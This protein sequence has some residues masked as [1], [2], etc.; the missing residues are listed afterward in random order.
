MKKNKELKD[1]EGV[2]A[3]RKFL[4]NST[5]IA[6]GLPLLSGLFPV[7]EST[8]SVFKAKGLPISTPEKGKSIIGGYGEWAASML[9][10]PA[11]LSFRNKRWSNV[12][13]WKT[14]ALAK[15]SE[16]LAKPVIKEVPKVTVEKKYSY[17]GLD[18]EELSWQLS[19]GNPTKAIV[20][21]PKNIKKP[22]PAILALHDHGGKKYF[23]KRKITKTSDEQH[24]LIIDHQSQDYGGRAWANEV[25]KRGYVVLVHDAFAFASRRVMYQD[26]EGIEWG[27]TFIGDKTDANPDKPEHVETYNDWS[28][29][30]ENTI[31]Q[32]LFCAGTTLPGVVL[33]EDQIAL[34]I[35]SARPDVDA[36]RI[37]C[38]GLSG[39]GLRTVFLGGMD[40][41]IKCAVCVG[42][43]ST[44][45]D[46]VRYKSY[47]HTWMMFAPLLPNYLDF[48]EI[49]GLRTP[50]PTLVQSNTEDDLYTLSEMKKSDDI[51]KEVYAKAGAQDKY[52]T[53]FYKGEHKFDVEMQADA[54]DWFD[55]W[56]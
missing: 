5:T 35:L 23:G 45:E 24:P 25:A 29:S 7:S 52:K 3:R 21:K 15:T 40:K 41:R 18:I 50:L 22:L 14:E 28:G 2:S 55:K 10:E 47:T 49:L 13:T 1:L 19:Y 31:A 37:G 11:L 56:L 51:L 48:P 12:E 46:F 26:V 9:K 17:D 42:F 34:D 4:K 27:E 44:W 36:D 33:A 38:G 39:G 54:F 8:A 30:H 6:A 32:S 16:L 20:L 43:M 53:N